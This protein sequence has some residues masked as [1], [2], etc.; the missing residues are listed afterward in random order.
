MVWSTDKRRFALFSART[1]VRD[2]HYHKFL[3]YPTSK[4]WTWTEPEFRLRW[5]KLCSNDHHYTTAKRIKISWW[6][7]SIKKFVEFWIIFT[8]IYFSFY[9]Y[10]VCFYLCFCFFSWYSFRYCLFCSRNKTLC[11][12]CK[13]WKV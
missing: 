6:V 4:I 3:R 13:N 9:S 8:L 7:R 11:N 2:P 10:W 5:M 1:I 12:N